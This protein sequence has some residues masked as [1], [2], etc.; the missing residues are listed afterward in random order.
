MLIPDVDRASWLLSESR[1]ADSNADDRK[2]PQRLSDLEIETV[3]INEGEGALSFAFRLVFF[4]TFCRR[5][6]YSNGKEI[7]TASDCH[8]NC[9]GVL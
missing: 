5:S 8:S 6:P 1:V 9:F 3:Y 4:F 2:D 7:E